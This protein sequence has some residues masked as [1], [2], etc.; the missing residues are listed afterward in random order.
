[1][2]TMKFGI[3]FLTPLLLSALASCGGPSRE[4]VVANAIQTTMANTL[5]SFILKSNS[6][7][8]VFKCGDGSGD[9]GTMTYST[10]TV[11]PIT[12]INTGVATLPITFTD[13]VINACGQKVTLNGSTASF[14]AS[15]STILSGGDS[16]TV[17]AAITISL[18]GITATGI[19]NGSLSFSYILNAISST[20]GISSIVIQDTTP[21]NPYKEGS[22]TFLG[23]N[24]TTLAD[25]C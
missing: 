16:T 25:G 21:A 1:M 2:G 10:S 20:K 9:Q 17:P 13:C 3:G 23:P 5:V 4:A 11:D 14:A 19:F 22:A 15:V 12:A 24:L 8:V 6:A 18:N 7:S